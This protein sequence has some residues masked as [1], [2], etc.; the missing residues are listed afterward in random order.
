[1]S[2]P[3]HDVFLSFRGEDTRDN[4]T[5]HLYAEL[6]RKKIETFID[7]RLARGEEI[8]PA[9]HRAIEQSTIYVV[10]L[11][12][13]YA[14][15]TWCLDELIE[16]LKCKERYGREVI[17]VFYKVDPS[18][19]RHQTQSYADDFVKHQLRFGSKVDAWKAALT[20]VA[21]LSGWDS[22]VTR[23]ESTLVT[24][25]VKDILKKLNR[26]FLSYYEGMTGIDMHIEQIQSLL[27]LESPAVRSIGIWGMGGMGKTTIASAVFEKLASQFSSNSIVLNVQQKIE[28]AGLDQVKSKYLSKLLDEDIRSSDSNFSFDPRLKET[29]VLLVFDDVKDSDQLKDLIGT[30]SNFGQG[31]RIIVTSRNKQVLVNANAHE[32]YQVRGMDDEDSLKLFC[33]FAFKQNHPIESYVSLVE[34][35]LDYAKGLPLALKV[36]GSLLYGK[37]KEVWESQLQK[38]KKFP[39]HNIFR[40]LK[41]SYD[42]LDD[43]QKDIF[44]DIACF[45]RGELEKEVAQILDYCSFSARVG[46]DV[47]KDRC[48]ISISE[49]KIWMHD[50]IQEMGHETVRLECVN[51]PGKRSRVWKSDDIHDVLSKNKGKGTDAIQCIFI[52]TKKI[53]KVQLHDKTFKKMH[54]LRMIKIKSYNSYGNDSNV[55]FDAFRFPDHLKFL[56]WE[57]FPQKSLQQ[58]FFCRENLVILEM[59]CSN[60]EQ[61]WEEDQ[62]L[63]NLKRLNLSNSLMLEGLPDL[64]NLSPNIEDVILS[65]CISLINVYSSSFLN[66]L[67]RLCLE[68]CSKLESLMIRSNILSRSSGLV[69]LHGCHN[70]KILLY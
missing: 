39:D 5:S 23:P 66:N 46:M 50:L 35:V 61:L 33:S 54:N 34:K 21:G 60:L 22:Q 16:I 68:G 67:N 63:P 59:I 2:D 15:S 64:Y 1:M 18:N 51:D 48:L 56:C 57:A 49:G 58:D 28:K 47:L 29:K 6:C 44:L 30:H 13:H 37:T 27:L 38:L 36:L 42:G 17:P 12:E 52:D 7:N 31:S 45:Y 20:Q 69:A 32:I 62:V 55:T 25:I 14:S 19:I 41:L 8:S 53:K 65:G 4:F 40:L 11:S 10:I 70:L 3:K 24:N 26:C 9:L 43:E